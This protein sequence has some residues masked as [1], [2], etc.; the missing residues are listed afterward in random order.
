MKQHNGGLPFYQLLLILILLGLLLPCPA[1]PADQTP[2]QRAG[3]ELVLLTTIP[4][5]F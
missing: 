5:L 2:V 1:R 3:H 4:M